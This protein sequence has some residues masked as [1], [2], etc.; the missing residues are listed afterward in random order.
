ML[1]PSVPTT[2]SWWRVFAVL[3]VFAGHAAAAH[4]DGATYPVGLRQ[5]EYVEPKDHRT[6]WM[7]VFYPAV[8][9]EHAAPLFTL[10]LATNLS[11]HPDAEIAFDGTRRPLIMLSHGRGSSAWEYAWFAQALASHGYIVAALNHYHANRYDSEIAYLANK[12]WQRPRDVS[13]DITFLLDDGFWSRFIDPGRIG[14]AGHSQGGF[15][16][17]WIGGARVNPEKFLA[18]QRLFVDNKQIPEHIRRVLP[19]DAGPALDVADPR[20]RAVFA[21]AAGLVQVFGMDADGLGRMSV[22]T[23]LVTGAGDKAVPPQENAEFAAQY[24]RDA[25][26]WVIPGPVGHEIF[27]NECTQSGRDET[28]EGCID[29]PGVDRARLH[30][31]IAAA[32][33]KFFGGNLHVP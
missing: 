30:E 20:V 5:V 33:V 2:A 22:P 27:T 19:L 1:F 7:A 25:K 10:P 23:Y 21:M 12:I 29:E 32:A 31:E 28:P 24:I 26:L 15:T 11:L 17:L 9:G 18:F 6:M 3:G 4:A 16:S 14:M 13:L 8:V